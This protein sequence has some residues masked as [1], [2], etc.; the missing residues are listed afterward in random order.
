MRKIYKVTTLSDHS[1]DG[2][3]GDDNCDG[4]NDDVEWVM[5]I[6]IVAQY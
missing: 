2:D 1:S 4:S 6:L 3:N 5:A